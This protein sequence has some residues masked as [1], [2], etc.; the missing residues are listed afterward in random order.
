M[1]RHALYDVWAP[2]NVVWS[3]WVKPVLFAHWPRP[4]PAAP[5]AP[6]FDLGRLPPPAERWAV[7]AEAP[8]ADAVA[9][10][11]AL[12]E[13][14]YRPVPLF[15]ALPPPVP[16]STDPTF[17]LPAPAAV[18]VLSI[19]AALV[20]GAERLAR[21]SLPPD[22]PPAFLTDALRHGPVAFLQPGA[23]DNRSI[24]FGTDVPSSPFLKDRGVVGVLT[25]CER[26][27]PVG[28]DLVPV[29]REWHKDGL[30]LGRKNL[31]DNAPPAVWLPREPSLLG[32]WW[33]RLLA[34]FGFHPAP[35]GGF[36]GFVPVGSAG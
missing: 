16:G 14:G 8:G 19:L 25:V 9:L 12:A 22:A 7:V 2:P 18:D 34:F 29:L 33:R 26:E 30:P 24:H 13:R 27:R 17:P 5:P 1:D 3:L 23:F 10:G 21:L 4:L 31:D 15:N 36:G 20:E 28:W 32:Y 35:G 6:P 11:L